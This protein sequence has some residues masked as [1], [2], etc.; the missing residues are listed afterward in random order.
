[1]KDKDW[2]IIQIKGRWQLN[3]MCNPGLDP[4]PGRVIRGMIDEIWT[5][6]AD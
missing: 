5:K 4:S 1:M 3:A 2:E 6:S